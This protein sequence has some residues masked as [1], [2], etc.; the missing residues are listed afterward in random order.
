MIVYDCISQNLLATYGA[1]VGTCALV[2]NFMRYR[3]AVTNTKARLKLEIV[4][5]KTENAFKLEMSPPE[6]KA[7]WEGGSSLITHEVKIRNLSGVPVHI[8]EVWVQTQNGRVDAMIAE[9]QRNIYEPVS[10]QG[11]VRIAPRSSIR[12]PVFSNKEKG[13]LKVKRAYAIDETGKDWRS[14]CFKSLSQ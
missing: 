7:P 1:A 4:A 8:Q 6:E 12:F 11:N 10:A 9:S 2:L 5:K 3:N 13:Y 14:S